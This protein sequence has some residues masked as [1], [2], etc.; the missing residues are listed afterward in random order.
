M[1][2]RRVPQR[3]CVGCRQV[4]GKKELLRI[5]RDPQGNVHLDPSGRA[6]GRGAYICPSLSC[7]EQAVATKSLERALARPMAA[8][9]VE[10]LRQQL[11]ESVK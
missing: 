6:S 3:T 9:L 7:L 10:T 1:R 2:P 5:V 4:K 11:S 8:E